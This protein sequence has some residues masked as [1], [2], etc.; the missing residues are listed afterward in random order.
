[1]MQLTRLKKEHYD[2]KTKLEQFL[3]YYDCPVCFLMRDNILECPQCKSR[4]C[5]DCLKDFSKEEHKKNPAFAHDG[6]YKCMICLKVHK[7]LPMHK[8]LYALLQE[9]K[10]KCNDCLK[11]MK[12]EKLKK[13]K[14]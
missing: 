12:L 2:K 13:H 4:A 11:T 9:L 6:V 10:F 7:Q 5:Q 3:E 1:M 14:Q 8:F